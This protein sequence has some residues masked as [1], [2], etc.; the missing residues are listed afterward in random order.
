MIRFLATISGHDILQGDDL[1]ITWT[2]G[3]TVD[4]DGSPRCYGPG[5]LGLDDLSCAGHPGNWWGI[6]TDQD[7]EPY[8]Q[9]SQDPAP[10][11][12][13]STTSLENRGYSATDPRRYLNSEVIPF[14]VIPGILARKCEGVALGCRV[15]ITDTRTGIHVEAVCGDLGPDNHLGEAS[16]AV[17]KRLGINPSPKTGGSDEPVFR[18]TFYPG[19]AAEGYRLQP[20]A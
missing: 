7:G 15:T 5:G 14:A 12:Y 10:G 2:S 20:L 6:L 11:Y 19:T 1:S 17:A 8:V 3:L 4:G 16:I 13:V 9:Q 18:F